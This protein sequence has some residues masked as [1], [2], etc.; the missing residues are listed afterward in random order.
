MEKG[1]V[2]LARRY[3]RSLFEISELSAV[4]TLEKSLIEFTNCWLQSSELRNAI[5]NPGLPIKERESVLDDLA[6]QISKDF[7]SGSKTPHF[8]NFLKVLLDNKRMQLLPII[9]KEFSAL[10]AEMKKLLAMELT[11]AHEL[12]EQER[13]RILEKVQQQCGSGATITWKVDSNFIGGMSLKI[14]DRL[15]D[16]TVKGSLE[17]LRE[18]LM[19]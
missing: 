17:K 15:L 3:S 19:A 10:V 2:R 9:T 5:L 4:E 7:D 1:I 14:G 6:N 8:T 13:A 11:S 18:Q 16:G 12:N